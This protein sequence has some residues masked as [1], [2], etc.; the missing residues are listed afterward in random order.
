MPS[1]VHINCGTLLVPN[2]PTVVCHCLALLDGPHTVLVDTGIGLTPEQA[3]RLFDKF[4]QA[5]VSTTRRYG[6]TGLGL[7]ICRE[8]VELMGGAIEVRSAPQEGACFTV[9]LP[10]PWIGPSVEAPAAP[11]FSWTESTLARPVASRCPRSIRLSP[12]PMRSH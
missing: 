2:F 1:I 7:S 4:E 11:A 8:L 3:A 12:V 6:G 9:R 5:D 10:L